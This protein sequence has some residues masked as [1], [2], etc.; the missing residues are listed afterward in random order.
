MFRRRSK[1]S[2]TA[3]QKRVRELTDHQLNDWGEAL[4]GDLGGHLLSYKRG[5]DSDALRFAKQDADATVIVVDELLERHEGRY[6]V[7]K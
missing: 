4:L 7:R 3:L 2:E 6:G 1:A 5:G